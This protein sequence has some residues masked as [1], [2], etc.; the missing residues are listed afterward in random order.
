MSGDNWKEPEHN[1]LTRHGFCRAASW[2]G[3]PQ[4]QHRSRDQVEWR[5]FVGGLSAH[6]TAYALTVRSALFR[7]LI[8]QRYVLAK[9]FSGCLINPSSLVS[10]TRTRHA[11]MR[12]R[13]R[14][15]QVPMSQWVLACSVCLVD[16]ANQFGHGLRVHLRHDP[17]TMDLDSLYS[18]PH[19]GCDLLVQ[20]AHDDP[21]H[22][23]LFA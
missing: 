17:A 19:P 10:L 7:W 20:Q 11:G 13:G 12:F 3:R 4:P 16:H 21:R 18:N 22:H 15:P 5:P 14:D 9:P 8:E 23:R 6:S 1:C 2:R